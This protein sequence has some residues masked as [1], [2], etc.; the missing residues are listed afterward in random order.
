VKTKS[1]PDNSFCYIVTDGLDIA[2]TMRLAFVSTRAE[3][4]KIIEGRPPENAV[5]FPGVALCRGA[6]NKSFRGM[7][8]MTFLVSVG[9]SVARH[10]GLR[11]AIAMQAVGTPHFGAMQ[12]AGW[13]S[14]N[15]STET[16]YA[17]SFDT[18]EMN[19]VYL[20]SAGLVSS[21]EYSRREH[22]DIADHLRI[23]DAIAEGVR[24]APVGIQRVE[25][26]GGYF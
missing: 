18:G 9:V 8:L 1:D 22:A 6:T 21:D 25:K 20:S 5:D 10:A 11:S 13:Q 4:A 16:A 14:V 12:R 23:S 15:V 3:G 19:L 24:R 2:A 7:G 26:G 17:V